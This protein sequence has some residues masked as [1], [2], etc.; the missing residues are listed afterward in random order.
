MIYQIKT[1]DSI[2]SCWMR[3]IVYSLHTLIYPLKSTENWP[4]LYWYCAQALTLFNARLRKDIILRGRIQRQQSTR[5]RR[6]LNIVYCKRIGDSIQDLLCCRSYDFQCMHMHIRALVMFWV[7]LM[8][9]ISTLAKYCFVFKFADDTKNTT[10]IPL[11]NSLPL[12]T[13]LDTFT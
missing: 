13:W 11:K 8:H 2:Q 10:G 7:G 4:L 9:G 12:V 5:I 6:K 3:I 1:W